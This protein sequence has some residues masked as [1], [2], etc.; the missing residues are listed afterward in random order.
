MG[1]QVL[2]ATQDAPS[3]DGAFGPRVRAGG[4][5]VFAHY[6]SLARLAEEAAEFLLAK[7]DEFEAADQAG[8]AAMAG[9]TAQLR[10]WGC[11]VRGSGRD[12]AGSVGDRRSRPRLERLGL[13]A[14]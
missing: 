4:V 2:Q 13:S 7:A 8:Q 1:R 6:D 3:Y 11:P 5:E 10:V 12:P 14:G 9:V